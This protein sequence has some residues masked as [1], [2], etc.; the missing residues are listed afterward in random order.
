LYD[1]VV[2]NCGFVAAC[3]ATRRISHVPVFFSDK[4]IHPKA[5]KIKNSSSSHWRRGIYILEN[6]TT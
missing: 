4:V 3:N 5:Y 2:V 1:I 6:Q